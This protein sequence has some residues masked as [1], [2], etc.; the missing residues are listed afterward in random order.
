MSSRLGPASLGA[1]QDA[2]V[3]ARGVLFQKHLTRALNHTSPVLREGRGFSTATT[4][5]GSQQQQQLQQHRQT[6]TCDVL[7]VGGGVVGCSVA[8]ALAAKGASVTLVEQNTLT[9][10]STWHAAGLLGTLKGSSMMASLAKFG[11]ETYRQMNDEKGNSLVGFANTGSLSIARCGD[12]MEQ[13]VR[14]CQ[15]AHGLGHTHHRVVTPQEIKD[16]HPF[17]DLDGIVGGVFSPEDGICNPADVALWMAKDARGHG[18]VIRE[19]TECTGVNFDANRRLVTGVTTSSGENIH[20]G[21]IILCGGAWLKN[22]SRKMYGGV[23]YIPVAMMPHQYMISEAIA[24]VGNHLPVVRDVLN[25]YYLKPEVGGFMVGIFE[26]EPIDHLPSEVRARNANTS[27]MP[28]EAEHELYE[29]SLDKAG[30]WLEAAMCHVPSLAEAGI[31]GWL[32]G[33]DT[34]STDHHPLIGR[35]PA[36][37]NAYVATGFNSQGI[38]C[39]PGVGVALAELVADGGTLSSAA[40]CDLSAADPSRVFPALCDDAEWVEMRAAEGY[41]KVY[42]IHYPREMF[43]SARS[44]RL[45]P[46]HDQLC[47]WGAVFGETYGWERPLYF[48]LPE[49]RRS[50]PDVHSPWVD[51]SVLSPVHTAYSYRHADAEYFAAERRECLATRNKA[52]LFDLSSFGKVRVS[53]PGSLDLLQRALTAEMDKPVGSITYTLFCDSF[54]GVLGDLT[55]ARLGSEDFYLVTLGNQPAKVKDH[56]LRV[57]SLSA[58]AGFRGCDVVD[59]TEANAVLAVN[60]PRSRSVLQPLVGSDKLQN[61]AFPPNTATSLQVAGIELLALRVS[62]AGELGWELHVPSEKAATLYSA[63]MDAGAEHG[64]C[65]AGYMALL[66]SLR[67]EKGFVHYGADVSLAET[68]LEVGLAFTCKLR[69]DKPDF[70]GKQAILEQRSRGWTKRLVSVAAPVGA[71]LSLWGHEEELLYRNGELVGSLTSGGFSHTLNCMIG[72]AFVRG[73]P[74]VPRDWLEAG[75]YEV[76][77]PVRAAGGE[78]QLRRFPVQISLKALVDPNGDRIRGSS[79]SQEMGTMPGAQATP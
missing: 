72:M 38:Q 34:H 46:L 59:V 13:L 40:G 64:L 32:H 18:A 63:L 79:G 5:T 69:A 42:S 8:R 4:P 77:V 35:L 28:R 10:G 2:G 3:A 17:L 1:L 68:P 54:G 43:E 23:N 75:D 39:A 48:P 65:H 21:S 61:D 49:E 74:K 15:L 36:S 78:V 52:A 27:H 12:S 6:S 66:N 14:S 22:L 29:E 26:G 71:D 58:G 45:S 50:Q 24:G 57:A 51:P 55:V 73:P 60:G 16:I 33:P 30:V 53:G 25:K 62:Y 76:E 20:C 9:S 44:R 70:I 41:G 47:S 19:R 37:D 56:L 67:L 31:K 7:V 11:V